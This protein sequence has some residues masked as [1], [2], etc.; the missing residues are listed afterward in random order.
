M[1]NFSLSEVMAMS[2]SPIV[3]A[4]RRIVIKFALRNCDYTLQHIA[5]TR[6]NDALVEADTHRRQA[7]LRAEL[8]KLEAQ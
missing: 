5:D 4:V 8:R 1:N 2:T 6:A 7:F 3:T